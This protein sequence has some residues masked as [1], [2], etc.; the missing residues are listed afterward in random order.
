MRNKAVN[1]IEILRMARSQ[2]MLGGKKSYVGGI[3]NLFLACLGNLSS[4]KT[5]SELV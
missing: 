3:L 5:L 1:P 2:E 4:V